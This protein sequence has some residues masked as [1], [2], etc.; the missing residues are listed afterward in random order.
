M[1]TMDALL[2]QIGNCDAFFHSQRGLVSDE[3]LQASMTSMSQSLTDQ[4]RKLPELDVASAARLN[5]AVQR[6]SSFNAKLK[7][8]MATEITQKCTRGNDSAS[9]SRRQVQ[10][11]RDARGYFTPK[12]W[13][14]FETHISI[15]L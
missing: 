7:S 13:Q 3:T 9:T 2:A 15:D 6:A 4:I 1:S 10:T 14:S 11:M 8:D 12:Y 5:D